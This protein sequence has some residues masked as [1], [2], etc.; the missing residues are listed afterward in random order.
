M[1][2]RD[3]FFWG[4]FV[5]LL[6]HILIFGRGSCC[7]TFS[8]F[9]SFFFLFYWFLVFNGCLARI[10]LLCTMWSSNSQNT[11]STLILLQLH[12]KRDNSI[13]KCMWYRRRFTC[14]THY[15]LDN[16]SILYSIYMIRPPGVKWEMKN[17]PFSN[18]PSK[19]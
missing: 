19:K 11:I 9:N 12:V 1:N 6:V 7:P 18:P 8:Y 17:T 3:V 5:P 16:G 13:L 15:S 14:L 2:T 10:Y 4:G